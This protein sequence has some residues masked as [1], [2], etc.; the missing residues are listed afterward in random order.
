[1]HFMPKLIL[2]HVKITKTHQM[3]YFYIFD[4]YGIFK[5]NELIKKIK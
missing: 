3:F 5:K 1:M 4:K 2:N